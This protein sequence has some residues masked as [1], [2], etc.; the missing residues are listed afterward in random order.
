M[1]KDQEQP[2]RD[3]AKIRAKVDNVTTLNTTLMKD[4]E[5]DCPLDRAKY[6][7]GKGLA[8]L[9]E[10]EINIPQM[11]LVTPPKGDRTERA[12]SRTHTE[13]QTKKG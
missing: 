3:M 11:G 12:V 2:R 8:E 10:G 5:G 13:H 9:V 4:Q 1:A 7:I 6:L